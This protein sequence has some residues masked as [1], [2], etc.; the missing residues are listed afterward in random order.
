MPPVQFGVVSLGAALGEPQDVAEVAPSYVKDPERVM[1]WGYRT[2]HRVVDGTTSAHLGARAATRAL[3][4]ARTEVGEIDLLVVAASDVPDYLQ[5]DVSSAVA[6]ELG[7]IGTPTLLLTQACAATVTAF[8]QIAGTFAVR[9]D[10]RTVLLVAINQVSEGHANRMNTNTCV[11]SDGAAAAVLRRDH[12]TLRW[13][14]TDQ[15]T[16]P[17]CVDFFRVEYGG[18]AAPI[19]P[20]GLGNLEF[21]RLAAVYRQF[22]RDPDHFTRFTRELNQRVALVV[23]NAFARSGT[24]RARL[25][26]LI[27]LNDNYKAMVDVAEAVGLPLDRTNFELGASIGHCGAADQLICLDTYVERGDLRKGDVVALAGIGYGMHW[28]CTLLE[29]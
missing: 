24:D 6:R 23:D 5:W 14:A 18:A 26:R 29:V 17:E 2:F 11:S 1:A 4:R 3:E 27:Y 8:Q 25:T 12:A 13:L 20:E 22:R 7:M 10:V 28:F 21:D 15:F 9:D 16:D 19:A